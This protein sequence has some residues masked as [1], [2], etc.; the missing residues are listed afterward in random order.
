MAASSKYSM[1]QMNRTGYW[2]LG[3]LA[4][5][6]M[7]AAGDMVISEF[8]DRLH[9]PQLPQRGLGSDAV[10]Y[11]SALLESLSVDRGARR[12]QLKARPQRWSWFLR[13]LRARDADVLE[14][15]WQHPGG[16]IKV[17]VMGPVSLASQIE[18]AGGHRV[19]SD[20]SALFDL[21][22]ALAV[23]IANFRADIARRFSAT[24]VLQLDEPYLAHC[25]RG[26]IPGATDYH[27]IAPLASDD[28]AALLARCAGGAVDYLN[29]SDAD[30]GPLRHVIAQVVR[31][32]R[33]QVTEGAAAGGV[34]E[35]IVDQRCVTGTAK[36]DQ[37]AELVE[38]GMRVGLACVP[39][40]M[41][42]D[43][44]GENPR[45]QAIS[46]ARLLDTLGID[47]VFGAGVLDI[48]PQPGLPGDNTLDCARTYRLTAEI[49]RMLADDSGDL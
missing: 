48:C 34:R 31:E 6:S 26:A 8:G 1:K 21:A 3:P 23:G 30:H 18:L 7:A 24:T 44:R 38:S 12:W 22:D 25:V 40:D 27:Q 5:T 29:V 42:W 20:R 32:H 39:A 45:R 11:T 17:Q 47:R 4:G 9:L 41:V 19:L 37:L 2:G 49:A 13:D 43:D 33:D 28:A 14:E 46:V 35:I 15:A 16:V 10:G 36:L